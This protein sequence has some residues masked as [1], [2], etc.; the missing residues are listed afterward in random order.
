MQSI[1]I[2]DYLNILKFETLAGPEMYDVGWSNK[3]EF[4]FASI[5][6]VDILNILFRYEG[7]G[8]SNEREKLEKMC[9]TIN[10]RNHI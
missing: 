4:E 6:F 1:F 5:N 7:E 3:M 10:T 8:D 9:M 2:L